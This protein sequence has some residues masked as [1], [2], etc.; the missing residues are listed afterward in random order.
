VQRHRHDDD[1]Q[2][3]ELYIEMGRIKCRMM[4]EHGDIT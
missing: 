3:R 2:R 1:H 4:P